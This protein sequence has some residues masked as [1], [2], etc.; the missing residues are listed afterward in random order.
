M[1][2]NTEW[3]ECPH[4]K[5]RAW[6]WHMR[7]RWHALKKVRIE[8]NIS[9]QHFNIKARTE[10]GILKSKHGWIIHIP[11]KVTLRVHTITPLERARYVLDNGV[12]G[13]RMK[14]I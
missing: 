13:I 2:Y 1:M 10:P 9:K 5:W 6:V 3:C 4:C 8:S 7:Y 11:K 12:P 14:T